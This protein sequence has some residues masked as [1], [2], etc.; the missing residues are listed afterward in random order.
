MVSKFFVLR[1]DKLRKSRDS[2][3]IDYLYLKTN[4]NNFY[5]TKKVYYYFFYFISLYSQYTK[6]HN[7]CVL[8]YRRRGVFNFFK[9]TRMMFKYYAL[10]KHLVGVMK[11][12]W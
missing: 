5:F 4:L 6:V 10:N 12:S 8:S 9:L 11:S 1:D 3:F 2:K 7:Y